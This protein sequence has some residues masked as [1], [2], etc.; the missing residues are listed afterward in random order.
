MTMRRALVLG[1]GG[2]VGGAWTVGALAALAEH[3][4]WDPR[5]AAVIVGTSAGASIAAMLGAGVGVDDLVA[6][7]RG[8]DAAPAAVRRFFT[9]PPRPVPPLPRPGLTSASLALRGVWGRRPL[10]AAAGLAPRGRGEAAFLDNLAEGLIGSGL[11]VEHPACWL[12]AADLGDATR[13]AFGARGMPV[14]PLRHALRASWAI[15]G[16]FRPV[17]AHG[18][19]YADGGILSP[20]SADLV[21]QMS[22]DEVVVVAPMASPDRTAAHG[23][24]HLESVAL[25]RA[26]SRVL[27]GEIATLRGVG[28]PVRQVLPTED[29]LAVMGANFMS[30]SH[31]LPALDVALDTV[32]RALAARDA[33][34]VLRLSG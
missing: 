29:D 21:K 18:R 33:A 34:N 30:R 5:E 9:E 26:M 31:R 2:T 16:W 12:V 23:L 14:V 22:L 19:S 15:P 20:T 17:Q 32:P 1:C 11:W 4:D 7:Q 10:V 6:A 8:A 24:G 13:V 27:A 28:L 3:L 25:R